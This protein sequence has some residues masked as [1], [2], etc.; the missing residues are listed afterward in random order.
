MILHTVNKSP[1]Q[2]NSLDSCL[3][4][5]QPDCGILLIEDAVYAATETANDLLTEQVLSLHKLYALI[6]DLKARGLLERVKPGVELV[7]Y[8]GFV[9]LTE[10]YDTVQ[11]WY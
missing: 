8:D 3:R 6:P 4:V 7:D 9:Q 2:D 5:A 11:S 1:F 10:Q